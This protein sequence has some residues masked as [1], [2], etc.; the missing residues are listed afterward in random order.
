MKV[1][2]FTAKYSYFLSLIC[3]PNWSVNCV[4]VNMLRK[5]S[6]PP[7]W[8]EKL[9][10]KHKTYILVNIDEDCKQIYIRVGAKL[11]DSY[12]TCVWLYI[13]I[14]KSVNMSGS[15]WRIGAS[16]VHGSWV[17]NWHPGHDAIPHN[18]NLPCCHYTE[19]CLHISSIYIYIYGSSRCKQP[20]AEGFHPYRFIAVRSVLSH[21]AGSNLFYRWS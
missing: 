20:S 18:W 2:F 13:F 15:W 3:R 12:V 1:P 17:R 21:S 4:S 16:E 5:S 11:G 8:V 10:S 19:T 14:S 7:A 9:T 6:S